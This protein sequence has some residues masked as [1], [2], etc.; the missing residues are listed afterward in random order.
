M[1]PEEFGYPSYSEPLLSAYGGKF[2]SA[3]VILHPFIEL[4]VEMAANNDLPFEQMM[5][6]AQKRSWAYAAE[7]TGLGSVVKVNHALLTLYRSLKEEYCDS[8]ASEVL[9]SFLKAHSV[10]EPCKGRFDAFL[11]HELSEIFRLAGTDEIIWAREF[12]PAKRLKIS[13]LQRSIAPGMIW[14]P[15]TLLHPRHEFLLTVEWD[16]F[17]TLFYG[18]HTFLDGAVQKHGLEGFF[19]NPSH[20]HY[21]YRETVP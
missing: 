5:T 3:F 9:E 10:W 2:E 16:S 15:G 7:K 20:H 12:D 17:F 11:S 6:H 19:V 14:Y 21:W 8:S 13:E 4:P 18:P 1:S